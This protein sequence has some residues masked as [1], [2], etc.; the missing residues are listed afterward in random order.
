MV[1]GSTAISHWFPDFP[2]KPKDCDV[3]KESSLIPTNCEKVEYLSNPVLLEYYGD[4]YYLN[5]TGLLTLKMS[6]LFWDINWDKH[7]FDVQFLISRGIAYDKKLFYLLY[8][9]WNI[10]HSK[11]K[12]SDLEMSAE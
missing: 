1:I 7:M 6:H 9:Y 10:I 3:I 11:N 5:A 12:R 4:C 2:R 8:D